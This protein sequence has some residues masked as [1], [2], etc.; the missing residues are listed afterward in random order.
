M[1]EKCL[2]NWG[3]FKPIQLS[4]LYSKVGIKKKSYKQ[5]DGTT[6][7]CLGWALIHKAYDSYVSTEPPEVA[8]TQV[9]EYTEVQP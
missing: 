2:A 9:P 6:F 5:G 3:R 7:N 8:G 4:K 1:A